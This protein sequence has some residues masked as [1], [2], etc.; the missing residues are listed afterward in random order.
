MTR[1]L[2]PDAFLTD[3]ERMTHAEA[4]ALIAERVSP[5]AE[6]ET[7]PLLAAAGR[8]MAET[9]LA[10]MDVPLADN[11]AVDGYAYAA[12]SYDA[13][14]GFF[15]VVARIAAGHPNSDPVPPGA[16]V[17]IFTG[18]VMPP[19][20]DTVAMQEDCETHEQ[21]GVP[22]V[23]VPPALK[24]GA[25]RRKAGEDLAAGTVVLAEGERLRPQEVASLASLGRTEVRVRRRLKVALL[26]TGDEILRPGQPIR[27]GQV[28]DSNN[29]LL[30]A[31]LGE[32][33]A[34]VTDLGVLPDR[35]ETIRDAVRDAATAH[36]VIL[37]TGGASRGEEDH[38]VA[39]LDEIGR[40]HMWQIA[41]KPGRPMTFGQVGDCVFLGLPGNPVAVFVCFLLY[42]L[43]LFA[44]LEGAIRRDPPRFLVPAD[45]AIARKKA[46]R[47][48]FLRGML[49]TD[50]SGRTVVAKFD[51]DGSGLITGLREADGFIE[52]P[53]ESTGV[54]VG[55]LVAFL[56]F[57]VIAGA[58]R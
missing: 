44:R 14:G 10:P 23:V 55:D 27:P 3:R 52:L 50:A 43:P 25:N 38:V 45:F 29:A 33:A 11:S 56:P 41:V 1:K 4:L 32:A 21:D 51:R 13:T 34:S 54:A 35:Y 24:P 2:A 12:A 47:R 36:D 53:E 37:T 31:L 28:Y 42:G 17:R 48:E 9:V 26:S 6:P 40:R 16:A 8:V 19:G 58:G 7:V 49:R 39:A 57:S 46:D 15:P 5:V 22:Y 30:T 18:A 20:V